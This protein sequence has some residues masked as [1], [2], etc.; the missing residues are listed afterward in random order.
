MPFSLVF[1]YSNGNK[2]EIKPLANDNPVSEEGLN[3]VSIHKKACRL[4]TQL[5]Q[6]TDLSCYVKFYY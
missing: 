4:A 2:S 6:A 3:C 1:D 5:S